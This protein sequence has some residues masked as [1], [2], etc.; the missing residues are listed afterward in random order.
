[1]DKPKKAD[2]RQR[3]HCNVLS[4]NRLDHPA[5]P[6]HIDWALHFPTASA[7]RVANRID[8]FRSF[9]VYFRESSI[10]DSSLFI[11]CLRWFVV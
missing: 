9:L 5:S 4:D 6:A 7:E 3:A 10:F 2:F 11:R 1:M 8:S